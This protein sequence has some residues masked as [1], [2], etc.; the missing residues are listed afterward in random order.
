[1]FTGIIEEL[2][3]ILAITNNRITIECKTV[4][5]D[6]KIGD[7][8]AVN[9]VC[10]TVVELLPKGFTADVSPE[11]MRVSSI[12][13][14]CT[15]DSVNLERAMKADGRFGGHIVSGHIDGLGKFVSNKRVADFYELE[16]ELTSELS[17]YV[18]KKGSVAINGISL[19]IAEVSENSIK[20]AVIPH[21][22]ENTNLKSLKFGEIVN[23]EIDMVAKYIEKFLSTSDNKS[24][25]SLEFLQEHGF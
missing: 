18:I 6:A 19:T 20:I 25:I 1:M 17:K 21:T 16:I 10:L 15:G 4:I 13:K 14:L 5:A 9:G 23:I 12:G 11:T 3:K 8:I 2:G 22:Y 24:R 7:S